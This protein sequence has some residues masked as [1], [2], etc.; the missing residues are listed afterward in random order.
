[1]NR[2]TSLAISGI[3]AIAA[4]VY[5]CDGEDGS[6]STSSSNAGHTIDFQVDGPGVSYLYRH[7]TRGLH[8]A[9]ALEDIPLE[10]RVA[11]IVT[12]DDREPPK[13]DARHFPVADL[14]DVEPGVEQTTISLSRKTFVQRNIAASLGH[15]RAERVRFWAQEVTQLSPNSERSRASDR[16]LQL[17]EEIPA[18]KAPPPPDRQDA[19]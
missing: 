10:H 12:T 1:M 13:F 2:L 16:A 5:G 3:L 11:V 14:L 19:P 6:G 17:L 8:R 15:Q 7:P 4:V 18:R 9:D